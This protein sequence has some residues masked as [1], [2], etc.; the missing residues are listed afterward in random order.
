MDAA[1]LKPNQI[2]YSSPD[3]L[4][5]YGV[6]DSRITSPDFLIYLAAI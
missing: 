4:F 1:T 5:I 3:G 6:I 2:Y